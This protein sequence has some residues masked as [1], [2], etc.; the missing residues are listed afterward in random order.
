MRIGGQACNLQFSYSV[1]ARP[2]VKRI[3]NRISS[4]S[5]LGVYSA[6]SGFIGTEHP[7]DGA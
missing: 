4:T 7:V 6:A 3:L 1:L 2:N 5:V